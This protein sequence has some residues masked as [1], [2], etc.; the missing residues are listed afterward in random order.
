MALEI[1]IEENEL[2]FEVRVQLDG[3]FYGLT[4][5]F[6]GRAQ[7]WF[8]TIADA[9]GNV[10]ASNLA[11]CGDTPITAHLRNTPGIPP[12]ALICIDSQG[13]GDNPGETD[14]VGAP[15]NRLPDGCRGRGGG[16]WWVDETQGELLYDRRARLIVGDVLVESEGS[17]GLKIAFEVARGTQ[18]TANTATIGVHNLSE[19][20]RSKIE[21][22]VNNVILEAGYR[23]TSAVI[24]AG[25]RAMVSHT[26]Q[27][28]DWVT[29]IQAGDGWRAL[30]RD[31][32]VSF[33]AGTTAKEVLDAL[34]RAG[35]ITAKA[36]GKANLDQVLGAKVF[37][38]GRALHGRLD[39]LLEDLAS[40]LGLDWSLEEGE[41]LMLSPKE[42]LQQP[43]IALGPSLGCS[44]PRRA[45]WTPSVP[46]P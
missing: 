31:V 2:H 16:R 18:R 12:G 13:R 25:D 37:Q 33:G 8:L 30:T 46:R 41:L 29:R 4:F 45:W 14:L 17:Q 42:A 7:L 24:F 28:V 15:P 44:A 10:A 26:K 1:P 34:L 35:E 20:T 19:Q 5:R 39:D 3:E 22:R 32:F 40:E 6:N 27:G 36:R 43:G 38:K 9:D 23:F 21:G 11:L